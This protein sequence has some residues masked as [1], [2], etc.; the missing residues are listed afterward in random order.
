[1]RSSL[2]L[3]HHRSLRPSSPQPPS[4]CLRRRLGCG[5]WPSGSWVDTRA[6]Y[7]LKIHE[8][9]TLTD[10]ALRKLRVT[11]TGRIKKRD[12]DSSSDYFRGLGRGHLPSSNSSRTGVGPSRLW[13]RIRCP[14]ISGMNLCPIRRLPTQS[15][16]PGPQH[17][18]CVLRILGKRLE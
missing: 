9:K 7:V 12:R 4:P 6:A 8:I 11:Q 14:W 3:P 10:V 18:N 15:C 1:M 16:A 5:P 13:L 17:R 2:Y